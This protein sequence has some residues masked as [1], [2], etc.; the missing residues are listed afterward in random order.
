MKMAY[1]AAR[2]RGAPAFGEMVMNARDQEAIEDGERGAV[3][4]GVQYTNSARISH[5]SGW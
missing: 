1:H 5:R 4:G 3:V 2:R